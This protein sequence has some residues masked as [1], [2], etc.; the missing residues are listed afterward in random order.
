[1]AIAA[2]A[3][4]VLL[5]PGA[6]G[7]VSGPKASFALRSHEPQVVVGDYDAPEPLLTPAFKN[8]GP[9]PA[10]RGVILRMSVTNVQIASTGPSHRNCYYSDDYR[11]AFCEFPDAVPVGAAYETTEPIAERIDARFHELGAAYTYAVWPMDSPSP[12]T[13]D[14]K[15]HYHRGTGEALGLKPTTLS[16]GKR[17]GELRFRWKALEGPADW[18][19]SPLT[20]RGRIGEEVEVDVPQPQATPGPGPIRMRIELPPG[21]SLAKL[22][23]EVRGSHPSEVDYCSLDGGD[24]NIY[25]TNVNWNVLRVRIDRRVDGAEGR[26]SVPEPFN[27]DTNPA[28]NALPIKVDITGTG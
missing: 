24:G 15:A 12:H 19:V 14:Y 21:T 27:G 16:A 26:I 4:V 18:S 17:G 22:T 3:G 6:A 28:D 13:P 9:E 23:E 10:S 8:T 25:C 5:G 1:M 7:P 2:A 11:T 20:I